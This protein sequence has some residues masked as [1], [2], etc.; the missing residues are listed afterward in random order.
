[1]LYN[2]FMLRYGLP[3]KIPHNQGR[4]FENNL[5]FQLSKYCVIKRLRT[6]L[7]HRQ[8]NGQTE[9]MNQTILAMLKTLP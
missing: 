1:M 3:G 4:E 9:R 2:D 5:F 7:Y 6:T 8:T